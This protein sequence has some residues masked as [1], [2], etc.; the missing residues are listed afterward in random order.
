[1]QSW[2]DLWDNW[3]KMWGYEVWDWGN[4]ADWIGALGTSG[5]F[6][7]GFYLL[8]LQRKTAER[9]KADGFVT[10]FAWEAKKGDDNKYTYDAVIRAHNAT[11][12]HVPMVWV[13]NEYAEK[14]FR[15]K[16]FV[17]DENEVNGLAPGEEGVARLAGYTSDE[18]PLTL[19]EITDAEG[20]QWVRNLQTGT[21]LKEK[22]AKAYRTKK[23]SYPAI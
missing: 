7:F 10:W 14:A 6:A 20:R 15:R 2:A 19:I 11:D 22:E 13:L 4:T 18:L 23:S 12:Y 9:A 5:A 3:A 8:N 21:Y 16:R 17:V 1:M